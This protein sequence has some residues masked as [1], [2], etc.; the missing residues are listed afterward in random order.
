MA[1]KWE[2]SWYPKLL[3]VT[4]AFFPSMMV[5]LTVLV[6]YPDHYPR[7]ALGAVAILGP[8]YVGGLAGLLLSRSQQREIWRSHWRWLDMDA[9][10]AISSLAAALEGAGLEPRRRDRG[11][12]HYPRSVVIDIRGGLVVSVVPGKRRCSVYVGP[13][14]EATPKEAELVKRVIDGAFEGIA[15]SIK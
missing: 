5:A 11:M 7:A 6:G 8:L 3:A 15:G 13:D 1:R 14:V 12:A 4:L 2:R 10:D 9:G